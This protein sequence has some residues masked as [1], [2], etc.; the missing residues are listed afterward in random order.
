MNKKYIYIIPLIIFFLNTVDVFAQK[1]ERIARSSFSS[2]LL[3]VMEDSNGQP[4]SLGSGFVVAENIVASNLHVIENSSRGYAK[5]VGKDK[6]YNIEGVIGIDKKRDLVLL[7]VSLPSPSLELG[8]SNLTEVGETVY[9]VGNPQGLEGT[10]SEGIISGIRNIS[11]SKLLQL[12]APISPGSSGGPVLNSNGNVIG[13]SVATFR[14][15][16]NLNFAIPVNYL[17][18]LLDEPST[19]QV[20]AD[21]S[22]ETGTKSIVSQIGDRSSEGVIGT[23]FVWDDYMAA[24]WYISGEF[25]FS[26]RNKFR[27]PVKNVICLIVF[28]DSNDQ[29]LDANLIRYEDVIPGGLA[30]RVSGETHD[31]VQGLTTPQKS[32][33]PQTKIEYRILDFDYLNN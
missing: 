33:R 27:E 7:K 17:K 26:L 32:A 15:G 23:Q 11:S 30:K 4:T 24:V 25:S 29:P 5:I 14:G 21:I 6:K 28:Y 3:L 18:E 20:L 1:A 10:F 31:S 9:A 12:T 2:T 13:I 16:Q 22:N 8:D 19:L